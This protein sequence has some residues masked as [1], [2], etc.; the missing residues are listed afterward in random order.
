MEIPV[1]NEQS[2]K[3]PG[4]SEAPPPFSTHTSE[5]RIRGDT[6]VISHDPHLN[7][8]GVTLCRFGNLSRIPDLC[9]IPAVEA[10]YRF[11]LEQAELPP[12]YSVTCTGTHE[13]TRTR[14][15][16]RQNGDTQ[17]WKTEMYQETITDFHFTID[18]TPTIL[19]EPLGVPIYVVG[20]RTA[21][22]RGKT[23]KEVD[24]A[25]TKTSE[26]MD[27]EMGQI[28]SGK[29][30]RRKATGDEENTAHARRDCLTDVGLP[31]WVH[32]PREP[33]GTQA[34]VNSDEAR[35]RCSVCR[36]RRSPDL[37]R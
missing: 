33:V 16:M 4:T 27:L 20:D 12:T 30:F 34:G 28:A 7:E 37:R 5:I 18:L 31:P 1:D 36:S 6:H 17:V 11:L 23:L 2:L 29:Q 14:Q 21:T 26:G 13:E 35:R 32:L 19:A 24:A 25:P 8:D 22:Y 10:L 3:V 9:R 15:V